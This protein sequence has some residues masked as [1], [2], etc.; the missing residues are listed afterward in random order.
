MYAR[1][2]TFHGPPT[3]IDDLTQ[4]FETQVRPAVQQLDGF[5]AVYWLVDRPSG[6]AVSVSLW[7]SEEAVRVSDPRGE[8]LRALSAPLGFVVETVE[9]YEVAAQG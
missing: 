6:R 5:R 2:A 1:I 7:E 4:V 3:R 9:R 8:Q